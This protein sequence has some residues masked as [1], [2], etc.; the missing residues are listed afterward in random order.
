MNKQ[1]MMFKNHLISR[2]QNIFGAKSLKM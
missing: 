1:K 2:R